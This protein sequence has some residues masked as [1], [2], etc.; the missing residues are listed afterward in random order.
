MGIA[1]AAAGDEQPTAGFQNRRRAAQECGMI[2]HPVQGGVG[3]DEI[4]LRSSDSLSPPKR[5]E[6]WGEGI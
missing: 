1:L 3:K 2:I 4:E 5:G 6:G